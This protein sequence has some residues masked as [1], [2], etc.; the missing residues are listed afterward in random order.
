MRALPAGSF[1][2]FGATADGKVA[3]PAEPTPVVVAVPPPLG[4]AALGAAAFVSG[5][6]V[7][8]GVADAV[9]PHSA[10]RKSAH[11][12]PFDV[13]ADCAALYLTLHS[14]IVRAFADNVGTTRTAAASAATQGVYERVSMGALPGGW[15]TSLDTW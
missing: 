15:W 3:V 5:A 2:Y 1:E 12:I 6:G 9:G 10:L 13:P 14:F 7:P 8:A 11:F 4:A